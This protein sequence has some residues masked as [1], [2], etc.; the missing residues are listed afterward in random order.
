MGF[1]Q[2]TLYVVGSA[3][4]TAFPVHLNMKAPKEWKLERPLCQFQ[5]V[6]VVENIIF[7]LVFSVIYSLK[8]QVHGAEP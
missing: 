6:S 7:T 2:F 5:F 1:N 8:F 4:R 3:A